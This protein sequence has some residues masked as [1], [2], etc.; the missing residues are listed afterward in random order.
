MV[1]E[2]WIY[3]NVYDNPE[4][5]AFILN[6]MLQILNG[7]GIRLESIISDLGINEKQANSLLQWQAHSRK[8][9]PTIINH[10]LSHLEI[11]YG[12]EYSKAVQTY[13]DQIVSF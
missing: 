10:L 13:Y 9:E 7:E 2:E 3:F 1:S 4:A 6:E 8:P 5:E 11:I 12:Q